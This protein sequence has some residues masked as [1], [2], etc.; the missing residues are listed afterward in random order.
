MSEQASEPTLRALEE[1]GR[2]VT[3]IVLRENPGRLLS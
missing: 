3:D 2:A 1:F